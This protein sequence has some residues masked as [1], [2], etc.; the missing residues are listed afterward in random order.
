MRAWMEM[1]HLGST[2]RGTVYTPSPQ[3]LGVAE[4]CRKPLKWCV[5]E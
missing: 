5:L 1:K 4:S 3:V 2:L